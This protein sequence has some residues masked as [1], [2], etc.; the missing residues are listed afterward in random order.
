MMNKESTKQNEIKTKANQQPQRK[1]TL[2]TINRRQLQQLWT[3]KLMKGS[4]N[5]V[6]MT[7]YSPISCPLCKRQLTRKSHPSH[8]PGIKSE[9]PLHQHLAQ[10]ILTMPKEPRPC[11]S[12][13]SEKL[14]P[15]DMNTLLSV[16]ITHPSFGIQEG[17]Q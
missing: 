2:I 11:L 10:E 5:K 3:N 1:Y 12:L 15:I 6:M 14:A 7:R 16:L 13:S 17:Q 9:P 4:V 8:Q